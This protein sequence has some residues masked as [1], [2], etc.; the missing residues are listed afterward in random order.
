MNLP[1]FLTSLRI[2]FVPFMAYFFWQETDVGNIIAVIMLLLIGA[3]DILDGWVARKYNKVTQLGKILD[4][5]ADKLFQF[6]IA[7]LFVAKDIIPMWIV[8]L[9]VFKEVLMGIGVLVLYKK[10]DIV[11]GSFWYGKVAT[12]VFYLGMSS[13]MIFRLGRPESYYVAIVS[14]LPLIYSLYRYAKLF[15]DLS[16]DGENSVGDKEG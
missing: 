8:F 10:Q 9:I 13:I 2:I 4:P 5:I 6:S 7:V 11:T 14:V 15:F 3:T 12:L 16:Y 1:N